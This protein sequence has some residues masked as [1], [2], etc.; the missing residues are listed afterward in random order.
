MLTFN[1]IVAYIHTN[2]YVTKN[3]EDNGEKWHQ[4]PYV[5]ANVISSWWS[6]SLKNIFK[7][8]IQLHDA[9]ADDIDDVEPSIES[10]NV[11]DTLDAV[12]SRNVK[13]Y[14]VRVC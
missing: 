10:T 9:A 2:K 3:S 6:Q 13:P 7:V 11:A 1:I 4:N 12:K 5:L 8:C 14:S